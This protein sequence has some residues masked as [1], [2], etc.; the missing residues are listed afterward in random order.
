MAAIAQS[1]SDS[2]PQIS[3]PG[4]GREALGII[5]CDVHNTHIVRDDV[6]QY[7]DPH[8]HAHFD[9][10]SVHGGPAAGLT[11]TLAPHGAFSLDTW[12]TS[13]Q[14]GSD[15]DLMR[16]QLLD[17][18]HIEKAILQPFNDIHGMTMYG[19][20]GLAL[21]AATNEWVDAEWFARDE[22]LYG[23][24]TIPFED[25]VRSAAEIERVA[26]NPRFV[27]VLM[28]SPTKEP[29]GHPK[30]FPIYEA[31][32]AFGL[33]VLVHVGGFGVSPGA[34]GL[35]AYFIEYHS[36]YPQA[37]QAHVTSLVCSGVF[38]RLPSLRIVLEEVGFIWLPPLMWRLDRAWRTMRTA[39][40]HL[41]RL[42]SEVIREH[43]WMTTQP[44]EAP[45]REEY[46]LQVIEHLGMTDHILFSSDYPHWDRDDPARILSGAVI[47]K[48]A[49]EQILCSNAL[50]LFDFGG[51]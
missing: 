4:S 43:F 45:E 24:I 3:D 6:K 30:Y 11:Y 8:W 32:A 47:G 18:Y 37:F 23:A 51:R 29:L 44:F 46:L 7:L 28:M 1:S 26:S 22:R 5:D 50:R 21:A 27:S 34:T 25:G 10:G 9:Q 41:D 38:E 16:E 42:P 19:E 17:P 39:I 13:G 12:P 33:P 15:L 36:N 31:A 20:L 2:E 40:P 35:P 14:P 49:R 48:E